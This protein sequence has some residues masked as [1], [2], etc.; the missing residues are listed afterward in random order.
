MRPAHAWLALQAVTSREVAKF[1]RQGRQRRGNLRAPCPQDPIAVPVPDPVELQD[2][3]L[4]PHRVRD[5]P[6]RSEPRH[7]DIA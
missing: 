1:L 2:E 4:A 3:T 5:G 7:R 6:E